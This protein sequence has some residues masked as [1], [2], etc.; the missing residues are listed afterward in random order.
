M[1]STLLAIWLI[2]AAVG[3]RTSAS[4]GNSEHPTA[5]EFA[6]RD[7]LLPAAARA[8]FAIEPPGDCEVA[9]IQSHESPGE[10]NLASSVRL[11]E[12]KPQ[13]IPA[14]ALQAENPSP[15]LP[16]PIPRGDAEGSSGITFDELMSIALANNPTLAQSAA[17]VDAARGRWLQAGLYPNP[18][19][20]YVGDEIGMAG[21][22]GMQGIQL[23]QT[24]V[25]GGKLGLDRD[26]ASQEVAEAQQQF[27]AQRLRVLNDVRTQFYQLL[28][29]QRT[30]ELSDELADLGEQGLKTAELLFR[31]PVQ[32]VSRVDV[33]QAQIELSTA[34]V[35]AEQARNGY[36]AVWRRLAAT[37]GAPE[38][39]PV[40]AVGE[41]DAAGPELLW[42]DVLARVLTASPELAAAR[43][44]VAR[45]RWTVDRARAEPIP[46]LN[47]Q[48]S[49]QHDNDGGDDVANVQIMLPVPIHD[50]NQG[51]IRAA[52]AELRMAQADVARLELDLQTRLAAAFER[53][54]NAR[55]QVDRYSREILP[56]AR[57]SLDLVTK[58]YR[59]GEIGYLTLLEA[60]R[61]LSRTNLAYLSAL[62]Q[63]WESTT[64][65]EGLLL[66][67]SL[68]MQPAR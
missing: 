1:R 7:R 23:S 27:E 35:T 31:P 16:E 41:L 39:Q 8:K 14:T 59:N 12:A 62:D 15:V 60:Q 51:A 45:A 4:S 57:T 44:E 55:R 13:V 46:N 65:I 63:L 66:T 18:M 25:R 28:V 37:I 49:V 32:E 30:L 52:L 36:V 2:C 10:V 61:T 34:R 38:M 5:P 67:G 56:D 43:A 53:Y 54:S 26:A 17:R 9:G 19:I 11:L 47:V 22:A 42:D 50:K 58:A 68:Q 64:A 33:L 48:A 40:P 20:G 24:I 21:R 6:A 29:A 3:C